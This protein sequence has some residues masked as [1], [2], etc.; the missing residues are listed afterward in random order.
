MRLILRMALRCSEFAALPEPEDIGRF[1][2][3][4]P[5]PQEQEHKVVTGEL[6]A[7]IGV[8]DGRH[9]VAGNRVLEGFDG[10]VSVLESRQAS[11]HGPCGPRVSAGT[12]RARLG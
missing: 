1:E 5:E 3:E 9:R 4:E 11:E 6:A 10:A 12:A 2:V 8:E 7:L